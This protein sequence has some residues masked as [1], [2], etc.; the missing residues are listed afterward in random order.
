MDLA[1]RILQGAARKRISLEAALVEQHPDCLD[2]WQELLA[3][4]TVYIGEL[5]SADK[6]AYER[7]RSP[8]QFVNGKLQLSIDLRNVEARLLVRCLLDTAGER[9]FTDD[10]ADALGQLP[11]P[12]IE[13]LF[14]AASEFNG[15][16]AAAK[17]RK[18][19]EDFFASGPSGSSR[20]GSPCS[21]APGTSPG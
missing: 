14:D 3:G 13:P 18:L 7:S 10:Q 4:E 15:L 19:A 11:T 6:V 20:S 2:R 17:N 21:S 12:M 5:T 1:S 9:I 16:N 8:Q